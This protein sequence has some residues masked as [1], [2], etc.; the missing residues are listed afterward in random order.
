M[1]YY[2][3]EKKSADCYAVVDLRTGKSAEMT[4]SD[5]KACDTR[6]YGFDGAEITTMYSALEDFVES[7]AVY[8]RLSDGYDKTAEILYRGEYQPLTLLGGIATDVLIANNGSL[9]V[10]DYIQV[11]D[12]KTVGDWQASEKYLILEMQI[13]NSVICIKRSEESVGLVYCVDYLLI[14]E[15]VKGLGLKVFDCAK[16]M[17]NVFRYI[18]IKARLPTIPGHCFVNSQIGEIHLPDGLREISA[19]AFSE[20]SFDKFPQFPDSLVSLGAYSFFGASLGTDVLT[21]REGLELGMRC[22]MESSVKEVDLYSNDK[23]VLDGVFPSCRNLTKVHLHNLTVLVDTMFSN[24]KNLTEVTGS[25]NIRVF[26]INC[27]GHCSN[28]KDFRF[29][30]V[31]YSIDSMAFDSTGLHGLIE[32][33]FPD[34]WEESEE[35]ETFINMFAFQNCKDI[36]HLK[37]TGCIWLLYEGF[38]SGLTSVST[39]DLSGACTNNLHLGAFSMP[40]KVTV[41]YLPRHMRMIHVDA[42]EHS[43]DLQVLR[44]P[45]IVDNFGDEEEAIINVLTKDLPYRVEVYKD[46]PMEKWCQEN[47]VHYA[48]ADCEGC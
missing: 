40:D 25:E 8:G 4:L 46:S 39:V 17:P 28:L 15:N 2:V 45:E 11:L 31:I 35:H 14:P 38:C 12:T 24:C 42:V 9:R 5:M 19:F 34:N 16:E 44:L 47:G 13:P 41:L 27:F 1:A 30:D 21:L 22:F 36:Q 18:D 37:I 6:V 10:P 48:Y 26:G 7:M 43:G 32:L 20:V 29:G 33:H 3:N 23:D